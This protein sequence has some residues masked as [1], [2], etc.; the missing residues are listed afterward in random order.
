MSTAV[1]P[2]SFDPV[3]TGHVDLIRRA[4]RMFDR[5]VVGVLVNSAK[6]PLFSK[7][8]RVAM[9]RE[10]TANQDNIE[11]SSFE[12]LLVDFVKEQHAD[13]IVR[14][15]RTPGDF[16]YELP[17]AQANHK[18]SVQADTIFL[19]SAPEYSYI[20]SSAVR[21]LLR[22][23]ADISGYVPETVLRYMREHGVV[24]N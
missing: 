17:L 12:G 22:Y 18:L 11:V 10:I 13:A 21:E 9:L 19:A 24:S 5:L 14:G 6:Q 1:F 23:Q 8:E 7:E 20:S 16:E 2:G 15:L 4:S 3:T